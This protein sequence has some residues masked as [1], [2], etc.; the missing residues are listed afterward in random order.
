MA[1]KAPLILALQAKQRGRLVLKNKFK[2]G[3]ITK[4]ELAKRCL[5]LTKKHS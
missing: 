4:E 2:A 1:Y 5:D 3:E